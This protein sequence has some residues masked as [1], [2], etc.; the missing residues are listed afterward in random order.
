[1][2]SPHP[3][4][5]QIVAEAA[6]RERLER[7]AEV[8]RYPGAIS[9]IWERFKTGPVMRW[10]ELKA[11]RRVTPESPERQAEPVTEKIATPVTNG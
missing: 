1:M 6:R 7:L 9:I 2:I 3:T 11:R 8:H 4:T 5:S 10:F